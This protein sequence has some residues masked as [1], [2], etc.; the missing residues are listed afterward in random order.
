MSHDELRDALGAYVLGALEPAERAEVAAHLEG[1]ATCRAELAAIAPLPGLLGRLDV[2]EAAAT[3][4]PVPEGPV[5]GALAEVRRVRRTRRRRIGLV[6]AALVVVGGTTAIVVHERA[7][8]PDGA[9]FTASAPRTHVRATAR[10]EEHAS[11]TTIAL[12]LS[13]VPSD[14]RCRL[15]VIGRDGHREVAGSWRASYAGDV[16]VEGATAMT[17]QEIASMRIVTFDGRRL[18]TIP[19]SGA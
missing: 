16:T 14:A 13:G 12:R 7:S 18:V 8:G 4:L 5:A 17:R 3:D 15:V 1:C 2:D 19:V 9:E 11:G 6:A 10:L